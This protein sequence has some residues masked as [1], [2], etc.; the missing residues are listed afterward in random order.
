MPGKRMQP[1]KAWAVVHEDGTIGSLELCGMK[2]EVEQVIAGL[3]C[4][5]DTDARPARVTI[6]EGDVLALLKGLRVKIHAER[7]ANGGM[8]LF[9]DNDLAQI[10]AF[11]PAPTRRKR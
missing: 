5:G 3:R 11:L 8:G 10:D 2:Y 6:T 4:C 9:S 7:D 1:T